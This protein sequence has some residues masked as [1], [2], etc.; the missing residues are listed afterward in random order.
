MLKLY[1]EQLQILYEMSMFYYSVKKDFRGNVD[2][3]TFFSNPEM[4][5]NTFGYYQNDDKTWI[6]FVT[7][8]E[9]GTEIKRKKVCTEEEAIVYLVELSNSQ[10]F[11]HYSNTIMEHFEEK[12]TIIIEHLKAEYGYSE[13]KANKAIDYLMQI[14]IIAFEYLYFIEN[15]DYVPD[16]YASVF[17]G[18]TAKRICTE[19]NLT[20]LGAF[21]YMIYLHKMPE[22]ALVNLKAGLPVKDVILT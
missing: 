5:I 16:K 11:A 9:R 21:N 3:A 7:D 12:Q 13:A 4:V 15:G 18:Y 14:K 20:V 1:E 8:E 10:N 22:K 19:T 17:S 2:K 6:A